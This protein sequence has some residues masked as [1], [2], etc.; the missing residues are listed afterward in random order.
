MIDAYSA[1]EIKVD[2]RTYRKDV[3]IIHGRVKRDWWRQDG[4]LV[5]EQDVG[6]ILSVGPK[7]LVIGTGYAGRMSVAGSL[8]SILADRDIKLISGNTFEA[9]KIY[10]D[11]A[12]Q[13]ED[14]AG[15]FHLTC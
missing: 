2:G 9:T 6:E 10:N 5:D 3:M 15:A 8:R 4:H 1:G 7:V 14:V 12:S 11:L 13:G